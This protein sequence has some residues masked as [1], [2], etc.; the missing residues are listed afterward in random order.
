MN[1]FKN[2]KSL[3]SPFKQTT[4]QKIDKN[5][6]IKSFKNSEPNCSSRRCIFDY[7]QREYRCIDNYENPFTQIKSF[8]NNNDLSHF[9]LLII[10]LVLY[11]LLSGGRNAYRVLTNKIYSPTTKSLS[12]YFLNPI[13]LFL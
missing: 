7:S 12:D 10:L 11:F 5:P 9:I 13:L 4:V 6:E 2:N 3:E 1:L 8:Y